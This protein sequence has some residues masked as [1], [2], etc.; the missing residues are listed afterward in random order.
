MNIRKFL[1]IIIS[2]SVGIILFYFFVFVVPQAFRGKINLSP[3]IL[4]F[5]II[6]IRWY[7]F[8]IAFAILISY[9]ISRKNFLKIH[10]NKGDDF[11]G[12]FLIIFILGLFGAR[13]GFILQ[14]IP[15]YSKNIIEIFKIWDGGLSI[16]GALIAGIIALFIAQKKYKINL[17]DFANSIAPQ[18]LL[19]GAIGR[20]GNFFNQE[21]IGKP[22][23]NVFWKMFIQPENRPI[24]FESSSFYHPVF[25]YESILLLLAYGVYLLLI[26]KFRNYL[27][28]AYTLISYSVIRIIVEFWRIDYKPIFWKLD[29]AQLV[30]SAI[31]IITILFAFVSSATGLTKGKK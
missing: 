5:G 4:E 26:K 15:Y 1:K 30:S 20:F 9:F 31:I 7:G 21:I 3:F 25:L 19:S 2:L 22:T 18:V 8:L 6:K 23:D 17:F 27:A 29:L 16:H 11:D 10:K 28:F 14:N 24:G 13:I 12:A